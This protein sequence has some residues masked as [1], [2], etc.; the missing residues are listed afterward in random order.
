MPVAD[1]ATYCRMLD[2]DRE[3]RFAGPAS[4]VT[5]LT[6]ANGVLKGLAENGSDGKVGR[7]K[8]YDPR[9]YLT[10][11]E[12]SLAERVKQAVRDL[13]GTSSTIFS[14]RGEFPS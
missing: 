7:K 13:G 12:T 2:R 8:G 10:F 11:A 9:K 4:N 3:R 14:S 5:S 6:M 1:Y